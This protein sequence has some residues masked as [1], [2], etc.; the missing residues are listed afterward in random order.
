MSILAD[1]PITF[2]RKPA[3]PPGFT[4][5]YELD[6][7]HRII[8]PID[9]HTAS[10]WPDVDGYELSIAQQVN[11]RGQILGQINIVEDIR[12]SPYIRNRIN[13]LHK[14]VLEARDNSY[15][16]LNYVH[17][18]YISIRTS[19]D[20]QK[21]LYEGRWE[22][23]KLSYRELM[24][25]SFLR[26]LEDQQVIV[27]NPKPA[28]HRIV[29][30]ASDPVQV[31]EAQKMFEQAQETKRKPACQ[32]GQKIIRIKRFDP[33]LEEIL[34]LPTKQTPPPFYHKIP[35]PG[36]FQITSQFKYIKRRISLPL[37]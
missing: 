37:V 12:L 19:A 20:V 11:K 3:T 9:A 17:Q 24:R 10:L 33:N 21:F 34:L 29:W 13:R 32:K 4:V 18:G 1:I 31:E 16:K 23:A 25:A 27:K 22:F 26:R 30:D 35:P 28:I 36:P 5:F 15:C 6:V 14:R 8:R 2:K 7:P